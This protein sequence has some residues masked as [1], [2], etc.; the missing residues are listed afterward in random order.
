MFILLVGL[1]G[2]G[3]LI[4]VGRLEVSLGDQYDRASAVG[5]AAFREMKVR[6]MLR[7]DAGCLA[8][9]GGNTGPLPMW[10]TFNAF[11]GTDLT[12]TG[13]GVSVNGVVPV[14]DAATSVFGD[15]LPVST[16]NT[17][18]NNNTYYPPMAYCLDPWGLAYNVYSNSIN[19]PAV[20]P[21]IGTFPANTE[22][23]TVA[24]YL[25]SQGSTSQLNYMT[26]ITL[27]SSPSISGSAM[28]LGA[29][30][31]IFRSDDDLT[32]FVPGSDSGLSVVSGTVSTMGGNASP[33]QQFFP[34]P[35]TGG[36][37][38]PQKRLSDGN[39]S[40]MVTIVPN[41][42]T[43]VPV[44]GGNYSAPV[45]NQPYT[46]SV[47]VFYKRPVQLSMAT[48]GPGST[49]ATSAVFPERYA[50]VNFNGTNGISGGEV[51]LQQPVG[52]GGPYNPAWLNVKRGQWILLAGQSGVYLDP[53]FGINPPGALQ[54]VWVYRW[55]RVVAADD[56]YYLN[57]T[58]QV[59][60]PAGSLQSA[61]ST[62]QFYR[63][64]TLAGPDWPL[65]AI[66]QSPNH[67]TYA[68]L[69][70]GVVGVYEKTM[71]LERPSVWSTQ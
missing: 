18:Q 36:T 26:R 52:G 41:S 19:N 66:Q 70:D 43:M 57:G 13:N 48:P 21:Y 3:A 32:V 56:I 31:R 11:T 17:A 22:G 6:G 44:T 49:V 71:L 50:L 40:W 12:L 1:L 30:E 63:N 33:I 45:N 46:V 39:Y 2:V 59:A 54:P 60:V 4:P 53:S 55:Y 9:S 51:T 27:R 20:A 35:V 8:V 29:A 10:L 16:L 15:G 58:T 38:Y 25:Q 68:I 28:T 47:V 62:S 5:R 69:C 64:V 34:S 24:P 65:Q 23:A 14:Q 61:P 37:I 67:Q 42:P 7:P